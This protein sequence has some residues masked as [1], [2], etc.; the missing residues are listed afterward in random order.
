[1]CVLVLVLLAAAV[2]GEQ[3]G[4]TDWSGGPGVTGP[5]IDWSDRFDSST[6]IA[7]QRVPGEVS[8]VYDPVAQAIDDDFDGSASVYACDVDGDGRCDVLA[9]SYTNASHV[10]LWLN[11]GGDPIQW[12]EQTVD[13][14]FIGALCTCGCDVD[15]DQDIDVL[16]AAFSDGI[17]WWSNDGGTPPQWSEYVI[18]RYFTGAHWVRGSDVDGDGDMDVVGAANVL[19]QVA[20]WRNDGGDPI[21]WTKQVIGD[22]FDGTQSCHPCD[23]DDD[24]D[25]DV[26]GAAF[27]D[28]E[29]AWWENE[30]GDPITWTKQTIDGEFT[31][32][33]SVFAADVDGDGLM[34]ALGA[35]FTDNDVTLWHNDGG[36]PPVWTEHGLDGNFAGALI[37]RATDL[38]A[39]GDSDVLA[40]AWVGDDVAWWENDGVGRWTKHIIDPDHNGAWPVHAADID[41]DGRVDV[42]AAADVLGGP[43]ASAP[44]TWWDATSYAESGE[45]TSSVLDLGESTQSAQL[46]WIA[47]EPPG[48][49]LSF[50]FRSSEDH[51]D[52]GDW[53]ADILVPG[54]LTPAPSR[55]IQYQ[56]AVETADPA[57]SP[58][59]EEIIVDWEPL[60]NGTGDP[61]ARP[62]FELEASSP[63]CCPARIRVNV[64]RSGHV[65]VS[66]LDVH[67]HLVAAVADG[68]LSRGTHQFV[69][70]A[71]P[72]GLYVCRAHTRTETLARRLVILG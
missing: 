29:I 44:I 25:I 56:V 66:V 13:S 40:T 58:V 2:G 67:G 15:G 65:R 52:L 39:D 49:M 12:L 7:W 30:G 47:Q 31:G 43:G 27:N 3:A 50:R 53:S 33:H 60:Q 24:G 45:L 1:M 62:T 35:A 22:G 11:Q 42:V 28:N 38:D 5:V 72:A 36:D 23:V 18:D 57:Y 51:A 20:W 64:P 63:T 6:R 54:A 9:A 32:A 14:S 69:L 71:L 59:L 68:W 19:D 21:Q 46:S 61:Q 8:L 48:T 10:S 41:G 26:L 4:Q 70:G 34:D 55:Y 16:G 37:V 17:S